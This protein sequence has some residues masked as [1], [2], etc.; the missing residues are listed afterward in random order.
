MTAPLL[1]TKLFIPAPRSNIVP[2]PRLTKLLNEGLERKLALV[3][4]PAGS[5]KTTLVGEWLSGVMHPSAWLSL[6]ERDNDPVRFL[7][8]LIAA[9]Q[10][11]APS[12]GI[13]A[14][15]LLK[16]AQLPPIESFMTILLNE[17]AAVSDPFILVLDDYHVIEAGPVQDAVAFLIERM[18]TQM[19]LVIAT[20]EDPNLPLARLRVRHQL[21]EV[22]AADLRFTSPEADAFLSGSMGLT[23]TPANVAQLEAR[24]E[25]WIAGLQL[26]ALSMQ[27]LQDPDGF[28]RSFTGSHHFVLDYLFEEVLGRQSASMQSFLLHTSILDRLCGPLC[29]AV[30]SEGNLEAHAFPSSGQ[31]TLAALERA[32][33]FI[34]PLDHERRWYRYHH[35]FADLLQNRLHQSGKVAAELHIRASTW[36]EDNGYEIEAFRHAAAAGDIDRA[37][38]LMEG[39]GMPLHFRGAVAPVLSWLD[40]LPRKVL[41]ARPALWVLHASAVLMAG[42]MSSV[43]PKLIAAEKAL[44]KAEQ[45]DKTRDLIGHIASVRATIAVSR[46]D[47]ETILAESR[48]ALAYL[49]PD[50]LAVRTATTWTLAYAYQLHDNRVAAGKAY[51]DALS[52][53]EKI[54]HDIIALLAALGLGNIQEKENRLYAAAETYRR[55]L[56]MA[57]DS[58]PPAVCEAHLGLARL[59][60]EWNDLNAAAMHGEQAIQLAKRL[61]QS[62]RIVAGEVFL[63]KLKLAQGDAS[64]AAAVLAK[65]DHL[66]RQ[67]NF[68]HQTPQIAAVQV[69]ALLQQG[70][71]TAATHLARKHEHPISQARV[72]LSKGNTA[73]AITLL[74]TLLKQAE[75]NAM[76]DER[77]RA[78]VLLAVASYMNDEKEHAVQLLA[79]ALTMAEPGGFTRTF[80]EEGEPMYRLL[81]EAADQG[82]RQDYLG[83]LLAAFERRFPFP[84]DSLIEPLSGRELEVLR[85]IA[86]GL[87]NQEISERLYIALPTVKGHNRIIFDKLQVKRRTEAVAR[88]R[89]LGLL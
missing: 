58:P 85:L 25:G 61:E 6:D 35:L 45:D 51:A 89:K 79:D 57:G 72:Q 60:Y 70:N 19:H 41:D 43:E 77:L 81:H 84:A 80:L 67:Q 59:H 54:G 64:G 40:T 15:G 26:A 14:A 82:M 1:S 8:Y 39:K 69:L 47:A 12:M 28:I 30:L 31:E 48:R 88:A 36:Y 68:A 7:S 5:G 74:G 52:I 78:T 22:R 3:S 17:I 38:R 27:G 76:E 56:A 16:S 62:D 55:V 46:H 23:L 53:S 33:L 83:K 44:Q 9:L 86:Q 65:A 63:A 32:N 34:V 13:N 71:L 73:A 87:S 11:I 20:R 4:A 50:N 2:R 24:T 18:P 29:D 66:A 37:A 75:L 21:T 49:H 10:S 42:R